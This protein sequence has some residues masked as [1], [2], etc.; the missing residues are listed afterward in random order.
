[1]SGIEE[2]INEQ[3]RC[4]ELS[5]IAILNI[6]KEKKRQYRKIILTTEGN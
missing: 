5:D 4:N 1:M 3:K 6:R 2:K